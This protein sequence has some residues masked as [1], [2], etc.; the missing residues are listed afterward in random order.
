MQASERIAKL[1]AKVQ[2]QEAE[3]EDLKKANARL[4]VRSEAVKVA[5]ENFV[6]SFGTD[7]NLKWRPPT[8]HT[9]GRSEQ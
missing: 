8:R 2:Q 7:P 4:I 3:I 6:N 9:V 5:F 1:E